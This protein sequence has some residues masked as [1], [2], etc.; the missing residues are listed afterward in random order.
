M[1]RKFTNHFLK[2]FLKLN[3]FIKKQNI[4][5]KKIK[6]R[7][8]VFETNSSSNHSISIASADKQFVLDTSFIPEEDGVLR[9][10]GGEFGWEWDKIND[11]RTKANYCAVYSMYDSCKSDM[12]SEVL[13][14]QTGAINV[15]F[16][17]SDGECYIDHQSNDVASDAFLSKETL[18]NFIF[19]L[20]SWLFTGNDN[21]SQPR[22]YYLVDEY[23][24]GKLISPTFKFEMSI[25]GIEK[26]SF[27]VEK[28]TLDD[29]NE[30]FYEITGGLKYVGKGKFKESNS[31]FGDEK[32]EENFWKLPIDTKEQK[33]YFVNNSK[34]EKE[35]NDI[36]LKE[37]GR[38]PN[39]DWNDKKNDFSELNNIKDKLILKKKSPFVESVKYSIRDMR[40]DLAKLRF[41]NLES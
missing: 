36:F 1:F 25:S 28:L 6:K 20:N 37:K 35:I 23:K 40:T 15:E 24:D 27:F 34:V 21:S 38:N 5:M 4:K 19:N 12:L 17:F 33:I 29:L 32:F 2:L 26:K 14:E 30:G 39:K 22:S 18:R 16:A 13:Q 7:I 3:V 41:E 9:I 31:Y 11:A 10:Y 8:G